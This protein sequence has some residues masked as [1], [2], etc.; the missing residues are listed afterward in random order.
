MSKS[1]TVAVFLALT[2]AAAA[3]ASAQ[4]VIS[5]PVPI[6]PAAAVTPLMSDVQS[7]HWAAE[8]VRV[9]NAKGLLT[10]FPDGTFRGNAP[11][12]R[13]QMAL[14]LYRVM[15]NG[16][17]SSPAANKALSAEDYGTI[18]RG[19]VDVAEEMRQIQEQ[20]SVLSG[21]VAAQ[22]QQIKDQGD[23]LTTMGTRQAEFSSQLTLLDNKVS[24][25]DNNT[26]VRLTG[27]EQ[28]NAGLAARVQALTDRLDAMNTQLASAQLNAPTQAAAQTPTQTPDATP[29]P[30]GIADDAA[31][32]PTPSGQSTASAGTNSRFGLQ[33]GADYLTGN[34]IAPAATVIYDFN[35]RLGLGVSAGLLRG[36]TR[37]MYGSV[38]VRGL[39]NT[40]GTDIQPYGVAGLGLMSSESRTTDGSEQ[41]LFAHAGL[42]VT[43]NV[44]STL[45]LF[46]E[47]GGNYFLS[48]KGLGTG[49]AD[50]ASKGFGVRVRGGVQFRF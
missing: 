22:G 18:A 49:L 17:L 11:V 5:T 27:I 21:T 13:Y 1:P 40:V 47:V 28:S 24:V 44:S 6:S 14:I 7:G 19:Y 25:L 39:M 42:G 12:T 45:G 46:G 3:Q 31:F 4:P 10:G 20:M 36:N 8:A 41:D 30:I 37:G 32:A 43:Y 33:V 26:N 15:M 29:A 48:N 16:T 2:L 50:D 9:L 34:S 35:P 38:Q 23:A